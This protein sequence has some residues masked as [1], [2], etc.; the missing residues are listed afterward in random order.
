MYVYKS[1][2]FQLYAKII[3]Y[4]YNYNN[5]QTTDINNIIRA[6]LEDVYRSNGGIGICV[7]VD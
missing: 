7:G 2:C 1:F 6:S 4:M 5:T 3:R